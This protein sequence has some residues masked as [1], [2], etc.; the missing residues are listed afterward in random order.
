MCVWTESNNLHGVPTDCPQR[1]ERLGWLNNLTVRA[2]E[3]V[4]NF[5]MHRFYRKFLQDIRDEQGETTG[6]ITDVVPYV[7]YGSCPAD[8]VCSSYLI[9]GWLLYQHYGDTETLE[10]YYD[11]FAA[12]TGFLENNTKDGIVAYSYYGDWAAPIEGNQKGSLGA[13]AVSSITPGELMS[14]GFLYYDAVLMSKMAG[15]LGRK[16]DISGWEKLAEKAKEAL[17]KTYYHPEN[18]AY[19]SG[20]QAANTFMCWLDISPDKQRTV[21]AIAKDVLEHR[22][23]VTTGNICSRYIL[24]VLSENGYTDLAYEL[25][26]QTT[27][28]SWGYMAE[29]GATTIWER[30]EYVESGPLLGMASHD[31]P[32]YASV[33]AWFYR[34]LLGIQVLEPGFLKFRL[35]PYVPGK[36]EWVQGTLKTRRGEIKTAWNQKGQSLTLSV[37]VPSYTE[38]RLTVPDGFKKE[39]MLDGKKISGEAAWLSGGEHRAEFSRTEE[40]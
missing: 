27:Y 23:H 13:D 17:N 10:R 9:L 34:Y 32:M 33:S 37:D 15:V 18:G 30:W 22:N 38:C 11:G 39:W 2:E 3:A 29:K 25:A 1:D 24:E 36:L 16:A 4:Y 35:K 31:H 26:A 7:R 14:T 40:F 21:D 20:S 28:P 8:P 19:A 5:D 6:A 12:W